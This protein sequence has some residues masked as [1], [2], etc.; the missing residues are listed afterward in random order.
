MSVAKEIVDA[1]KL[2]SD[3]IKA[4][5]SIVTA[6][7]DGQKYL[8]NRHPDVAVTSLLWRTESRWWTSAAPGTSRFAWPHEADWA[9]SSRIRR[10]RSCIFPT[11]GRG[12]SGP[13]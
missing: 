2:L 11:P 4:M 7:R 5:E 13:S 9:G 8:K 10:A 6:C 1:V 12:D 3:G